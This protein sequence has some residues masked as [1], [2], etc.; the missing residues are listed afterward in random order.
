MNK[1][2]REDYSNDEENLTKKISSNVY[3]DKTIV[4]NI[5]EM[6]SEDRSNAIEQNPI[7]AFGYPSEYS[8]IY[9]NEKSRR[10]YVGF[11]NLKNVSNEK[12]FVPGPDQRGS[13]VIKQHRNVNCFKS[14][15]DQED[16]TDYINFGNKTRELLMKYNIKYF[17][18]EEEYEEEYGCEDGYNFGDYDKLKKT[19]PSKQ[20]IIMLILREVFNE[21]KDYICVAGGF[22]LSN[23]IK[24]NYEYDI[25]FSDVDL[26]IHSCN[27]ETA[28]V[29]VEKLRILCGPDIYENENVIMGDSPGHYN[30]FDNSYDG[31][32]KAVKVTIQIIKR[33]YSCPQEIIAGFDIDCCCI[34][35]TLDNQTFVTERGYNAIKN[36]YNVINFEKLS[37]SYEYRLCKY[38]RRGFGMWLPF[39]EHFK[40]NSFFDIN[41]MDKSR[42]S[43]IIMRQ[44][45]KVKNYQNFFS[46]HKI[47]VDYIS[48]YTSDN[49]S[50]VTFPITFKTLN[51]GEQRINTFHRIFLEDPKEWYP[52]YPENGVDY[53]KFDQYD[54]EI[55]DL[56]ENIN[57]HYTVAKNVKRIRKLNTE[58]D[59]VKRISRDMIDYIQ[60]LAPN[61][62][63]CGDLAKRA[64]TGIYDYKLSVDIWSPSVISEI[65]NIKFRYNITKYRCL[66][67]FKTYLIELHP[68]ITI[69]NIFD[70]GTV[71]YCRDINDALNVTEEENLRNFTQCTDRYAYYFNGNSEYT[72]YNNDIKPV[73]ILD[74]KLTSILLE[75]KRVKRKIKLQKYIDNNTLHYDND[76]K[77]YVMNILNLKNYHYTVYE[78]NREKVKNYLQYQ[79]N[80]DHVLEEI[81]KFPSYYLD[82]ERMYIDIN[83][84]DGSKTIEQFIFD[85]D[86]NIDGVMYAYGKFIGQKNNYHKAIIG[87]DNEGTEVLPYPIYENYIPV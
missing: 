58:S 24:D 2:G 36:G 11:E 55:I 17:N 66:T 70:L 16:N 81:K 25:D 75:D 46:S 29:I 18:I 68:E 62:I 34:L 78:S 52:S 49:N 19:Y 6:T 5:M 53:I 79:I 37:P 12:I 4:P 33:L 8:R 87:I 40:K 35:T 73:L 84:Q 54:D 10:H 31:A 1:R 38:N 47:N 86:K 42:G 21:Y 76:V 80:V 50:I 71:V 82:N 64:L 39:M 85:S 57:F 74:D 30:Y 20:K 83:L 48:D 56:D 51:P 28:N 41:V 67:Y 77:R 65:D 7:L 26:F 23:Y 63:I 14:R 44:L 15:F 9:N 32:N 43:T 22:S 72:Y 3:D 61:S 45:M 69:D 13:T 59:R 27:Q 60:N